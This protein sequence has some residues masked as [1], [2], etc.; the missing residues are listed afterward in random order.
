M[1][2]IKVVNIQ[3]PDSVDP[4]LI[5]QAD[6][7]T[8]FASGLTVSGAFDIAND[9]TVSG[10]TGLGTSSPTSKLHVVDTT[11]NLQLESTANSSSGKIDFIGKD[12]SSNSYRTLTIDTNSTGE[13]NIE[14]DPDNGG[15]S[16]DKSI[17]FKQ[18]GSEKARISNTGD[19]GIGTSAPTQ[20]LHVASN[21]AT[22]LLESTA[23][24]NSGE[25]FFTGK[26]GSGNSFT[27]FRLNTRSTGAVEFNTN[28]DNSSFSTQ[29]YF[30]FTQDGVESMRINSSGNVGVGATNP[31]VE[32]DVNGEIR[33][34][35]GILF[36]T[37]TAAANTLDDYEQGTWTPAYI[38]ATSNPTVTYTT[39]EGSY[40]KTG[41]MVTVRAQLIVN[42]TSGGSGNLRIG[43]LPFTAVE[44]HG[45]SL[46]FFNN[47]TG[48]QQ[49][50]FCAA[51]T[52]F[53][54]IYREATAQST[55]M[56]TAHLVNSCNINVTVTYKV[57]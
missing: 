55:A 5:L 57:A 51:N 28:P 18:A 33:A 50:L 44:P 45:G 36:G 11:T 30:A 7:D 47:W 27:T 34:S 22:V 52:T 29:S 15:Y 32:L 38:G 42:T 16:T 9:L 6:G 8:V 3:H 49:P 25:I 41:D 39:Q 26:D 53:I 10:N 56:T 23:N 46:G 20:R 14:T 2:T 12:A 37:D 21:N 48:A 24:N 35:T 54:A 1:S 4:N 19:V 31:A 13:V 43:G 40:T 17:I